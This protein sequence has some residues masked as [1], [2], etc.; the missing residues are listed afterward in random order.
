M[1][2]KEYI[3]CSAI[4]VDDKTSHVH[5]PR[6]ISSGIVICGRRHHNCI[7]TYF[8]L[9]GK[10]I[11]CNSIQGFLTN[12]D[13]FVNRQEGLQIALKS[14]QTNIKKEYVE[15]S[16]WLNL[17]PNTPDVLISEDLYSEDLY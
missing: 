7:T 2:K 10:R 16:E 8:A 14:G 17:D 15:I 11:P 9:T 4:H 13:R 6:N 1:I 12:T 3:I 5:Q